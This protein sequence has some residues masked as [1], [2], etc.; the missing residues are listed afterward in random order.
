MKWA[1]SFEW[2]REQI[3]KKKWT[4]CCFENLAELIVQ[5]LPKIVFPETAE[6]T[7]KLVRTPK[8]I[9]RMA[10]NE[11]ACIGSACLEFVLDVKRTSRD[12]KY[13]IHAAGYGESDVQ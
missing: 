13:M 11:L 1:S 5:I 6:R 3:A 2:V 7:S 12:E 10:H 8:G 4:L 9:R